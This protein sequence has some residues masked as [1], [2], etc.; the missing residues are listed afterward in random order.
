MK[1]N[2]KPLLIALTFIASIYIL[3]N[4]FNIGGKSNEIYYSDFLNELSRNNIAKVKISGDKI[5]GVFLNQQT[6]FVWT[7][8]N[9][10]LISLL[11]DHNVLVEVAEYQTTPWYFSLLIHWGPLLFLIGIW[12]FMIRKSSKGGGSMIFSIGKSQAKKSD[13]ENKPDVKFTDVAGVVEVKEEVIE[14]VDFLKDPGK[15]AKL[16]GKIPRGVLL[17]GSPGTGKTLL[18]KAIAG[19]AEVPF[20]SI[21]GSEFVEMFVGVGASR[22]RDLFRQAKLSAPCIVF[23]DEIDAV[24]RQRGT[25]LGSGHDEREQTL[26]QLLNEL[27]GFDTNKGIIA[28]AATN[29][30]DILDRAL[31]RPG[32]FDRHI[33]IPL[34]DI[35][36]RKEILEVH[37]KKIKTVKNINL[38]DIAKTTHGF[39]GAQLANLINEAALNAIKNKKDIVEQEHLNYA[40]DKIFIGLERKSV[41]LSKEHKKSIAYHEAGHALVS[42][43]LK[44]SD[45]IHKISIVPTGRGFGVT[46][47]L[48]ARDYYTY[49]KEQLETD[50]IISMGGKASE[51]VVFNEISSGAEGDLKHA[52]KLAYNMICKWGMS[53]SIGA[54]SIDTQNEGGFMDY[55]KSQAISNKLRDEID[56][57]VLSLLKKSYQKAKQILQ[58]N[59]KKLDLIANNLIDKEIITG[60]EFKKIIKSS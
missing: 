55:Y 35:I 8:F 58:K 28:I 7:S 40:R 46:T 39:S 14:V 33:Y 26:N 13:S 24:G 5:E 43:F 57:N 2:L 50:I 3:L 45:P 52:T 1:I 9:E 19:E 10:P 17:V 53:N 47:F 60:I 38:L 18:A 41:V 15:Y 22:V 6:F 42:F 29:R 49:D 56:N 36:S 16:G 20:F 44:K 23:I 11:N 59:R 54:M 48:P 27:D 34:P 12:I 31:L 37:A 30:V 4:Q 25:G 51:D 21:A 32:R